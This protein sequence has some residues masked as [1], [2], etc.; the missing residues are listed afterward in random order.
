MSQ[1]R[2]TSAPASPG[3]R[4]EKG[5]IAWFAMEPRVVVTGKPMRNGH[6][7]RA[8]RRHPAMES[9]SGPVVPTGLRL[10]RHRA[11]PIGLTEQYDA[12]IE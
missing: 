7:F 4:G 10:V 12:S 9:L 11:V 3:K 8:L 6:R 2:E 5:P 1:C